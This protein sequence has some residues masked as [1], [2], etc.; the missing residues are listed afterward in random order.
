MPAV[1]GGADPGGAVD[2]EP[3][4]A[5]AFSDRF[6]RVQS[7][8]YLEGGPLWPGVLYQGLLRGHRGRD[9]I[10]GPGEG[11]EER[12]PLGVDFMAVSSDERVPKEP[13]VFPQ[14]L[15][16]PAIAEA[17][18]KHGRPLDVGKQEGDRPGR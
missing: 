3:N 7:H 6:S 16:V 10:P 8:P 11:H 17:L 5:R 14:D 12:I 1:T 2:P 18:E 13:L 4:I 9:R 15:R